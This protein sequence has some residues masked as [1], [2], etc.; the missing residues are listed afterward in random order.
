MKKLLTLVCVGCLALLGVLFYATQPARFS[1]VPSV[2][3]SLNASPMTSQAGQDY[4]TIARHEAQA[5]GIPPL[6]FVRQIQQESGFN[7]NAVSKAGAIGI[8]Q[9]MPRTAKGLGINPWN[10]SASL[11]GAARLMASYVKRYGGDYAKALAAYNAGS[12]TV[13]WVLAR[14]GV[15]WRLCLPT[16]TQS[17]ISI[18]MKGA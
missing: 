2:V 10:P 4:P 18:I 11:K 13:A 8:A 3:R 15:K 7:P 5:A 16:E 14:C 1:P 6:L 9:F 12:G 17:Y